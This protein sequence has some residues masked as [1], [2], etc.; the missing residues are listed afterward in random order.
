MRGSGGKSRV[1]T[2]SVRT[3]RRPS[4]ASRARANGR[5]GAGGCFFWAEPLSTAACDYGAAAVS[6]DARAGLR[7]ASSTAL[8]RK[9]LASSVHVSP[10]VWA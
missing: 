2:R 4:P 3:G 6:S 7:L 9:A 5:V 8:V 1:R 10:Y